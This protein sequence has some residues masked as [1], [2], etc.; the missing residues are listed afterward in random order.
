M[1]INNTESFFQILL[2]G[3]SQGSMPDPILS[4][5]F[6]NDLFLFIKVV[7]LANYT[8]DNTIYTEKNMTWMK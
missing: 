7:E 8:D 4:N 3:V 6:I 1:K 5:I 2:S